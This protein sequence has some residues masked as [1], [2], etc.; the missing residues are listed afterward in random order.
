M[1]L[2]FYKP[3][4]GSEPIPIS[5]GAQGD[6]GPRG[7]PGDKGDVGP[8]GPPSAPVWDGTQAEYDALGTYDPN[9]TYFV[10]PD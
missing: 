7:Y 1:G 4:D 5:R 10:R 8:A 2:M 3:L 9:T 6:Q